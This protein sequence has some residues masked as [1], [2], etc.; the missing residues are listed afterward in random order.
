M[1]DFFTMVFT[2]FW[3]W[4]GFTIT[5]VLVAEQLAGLVASFRKGKDE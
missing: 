4:V 3:P 1:N 2:N 5:C